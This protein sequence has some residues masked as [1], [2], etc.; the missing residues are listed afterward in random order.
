MILAISNAHDLGHPPRRRLRYTSDPVPERFVVTFRGPGWLTVAAERYPYTKT[1]V[2]RFD[3]L[4]FGSEAACAVLE[5][6]HCRME[7]D[8]LGY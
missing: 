6:A 8:A 2:T 7:A 1:V 4:Y 3:T 5:Q